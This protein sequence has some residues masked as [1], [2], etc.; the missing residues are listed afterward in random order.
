[1]KGLL[2]MTLQQRIAQL[3]IQALPH[4]VEPLPAEA[5]LKLRWDDSHKTVINVTA[6]DFVTAA[7]GPRPDAVTEQPEVSVE[8]PD[9]TPMEAAILEVIM[10]MKP[11]D[12]LSGEEIAEKAG[13]AFGGWFRS[14]LSEMAKNGKI[15]VF[16][17][18][19]YGRF[20]C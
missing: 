12:R 20:P 17:R 2:E 8:P 11:D 1:M 4:L 9:A 6:T 18:A 13:Y 16:G 15:G 14:R 19:G 3:I 10:S 7:M 5:I